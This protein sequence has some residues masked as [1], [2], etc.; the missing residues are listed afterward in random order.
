MQ[1]GNGT[2]FFDVQL[3]DNTASQVEAIRKN[4]ISKLGENIAP[5]VDATK[6]RSDIQ[7]A[8][9][10]ENFKIKLTTEK[11][12]ESIKVNIDSAHLRKSVQEALESK[13][14]KINVSVNQVR[15]AG[16]PLDSRTL[17][18]YNQLG[19]EYTKVQ[20]N[21]TQATNDFTGANM[22]M[23]ATLAKGISISGG[24]SSSLATLYSVTRVR[25]FLGNVIEIG[26][27]LERQRISIG[28]ILN[29]TAHATDLFDRIK[30]LAIKS[31]FGVVELDQYTKQLSAYGFKYN[32]LYDMTKRLA[33][34]SA[35]AGTD[36]G[37][38]TLALGHVRSA[39]YLTGI[40]LRQFSMNNIPMLKLLADQYSEVEKRAVSTAE[41]Q[42][43]ISER[44]VSY[45]DVITA[46]KTITDEGG[47]FYNMQDKISDSVSAKWKN[48]KDSLDIMYGEMA[49]SGIGDMLKSTAEGLTKLSRKWEELAHVLA[50]IVLRFGLVKASTLVNNLILGR[51]TNL[52]YKNEMAYQ[53]QYVA[54]L[55]AAQTYRK[56]SWDEQQVINSEIKLNE[57]RL[58]AIL[59]ARKLNREELS[60][61]VAL[62]KVNK[63]TAIAAIKHSD[64]TN[65]EKREMKATIKG[66]NVLKGFELQTAKAKL[67]LEKI[68]RTLKSLGASFG[69]IAILGVLIDLYAR[70]SEEADR[71]AEANDNFFNRAEEGLKNI[72]SMAEETGMKIKAYN[73]ELKEFTN[74]EQLG[75]A[76]KGELVAPEATN[77]DMQAAIE[78][79]TE[80]I[81]NY[82]ATPNKILN[83]ALVDQAGNVLSLSKQYENLSQSVNEV[84]QAYVYMKEMANNGAIETAINATGG[85]MIGKYLTDDIVTNINDYSDA[86][87]AYNSEINSLMV[88]YRTEISQALAAARAEG[89]F[90]TAI[91]AANKDMQAKSHRNLS[92]AEQLKML[93]ENQMKYSSAILDFNSKFSELVHKNG[94]SDLNVFGTTFLSGSSIGDEANAV[95]TA[96]QR[97][98]SD[99]EEF[100]NSLKESVKDMGYDLDHLKE[101][102]KQSIL[103]AI[104]EMVSK[105]TGSTEEVRKEVKKLAADK[106]KIIV[107]T[108]TADAIAKTSQLK[109]DLK[110]LVG[111][112]WHIDINT[113]TNFNDVIQK[114]RQEYKSAKDYI[115]NVKPLMLKM[116]FTLI[117]QKS[118]TKEQIDAAVAK[119][120]SK[121]RNGAA[122]RMALEDYKAAME[123]INDA[124]DFNKSTGIHLSDPNSGGKT[125]R[126]K[127]PKTSKTDTVLKGWQEQLTK[128]KDFYSS[129]KKLAEDLTDDQALARIRKEGLFGSLFD[130]S[131]KFIYDINNM[132]SAF[133]AL[134]KTVVGKVGKS[135]ERKSFLHN[136]DKEIVSVD[137]DELHKQI[138]NAAKEMDKYISEN[139]K[140]FDLFKK[141]F[142]A[143][144][145]RSMAENIAFGENVSYN[146]IVEK[147]RS[148]LGGKD[149]IKEL[150]G[151][152]KVLG[153]SEEE[154]TKVIRP[155][156]ELYHA[157]KQ[158]R[159]EQQKLSSESVNGLLDMYKAAKNYQDKINDVNLELAKNLKI[160]EEQERKGFIDPERANT[161]RTNAQTNATQKIDKISFEEFKN[162]SDWVKIFGD[163]NKVAT[164]KL[165]ELVAKLEELKL[166]LPASDAK[167]L[168]EAIDKINNELVDRN[169]ISSL[170]SDI[171]KRYTLNS[172]YNRAGELG[173]LVRNEKEAKATGKAI[174]DNLSKKE[175]KDIKS[176]NA[177]DINKDI[178]G[179]SKKFQALSNVL[180]PVTDLFDQLG[181]ETLSEGSN[182]VGN[183]LQSG[184]SVSNGLQAFGGALS[185]AG[186]WGA[187]AGAALSVTSSL[188]ALH[189]KS[190]QKQIEAS[191]RREKEMENLS[192]NL[193]SLLEDSI[194]GIFNS[195][196]SEDPE[197]QAKVNKRKD[198][199]QGEI[200]KSQR[201]WNIGL[202]D[203]RIL[204]YIKSLQESIDG[205]N[206]DSVYKVNREL[207][208][209]ELEELQKQRDAEADKKKSD[210]NALIEY[211]EK[212]YQKKRE[213]RQYAQTMAKDLYDIDFKSWANDLANTLVSAWASGESAAEKY[214]QKVSDIIKELG[215]KMISQRFVA[216][217]LEPIMNEFLDQYEL[218][219]GELTE[220]G[221]DI[222]SRMY[223]SA[224]E[225][226]DRSNA[227]MDGLEQIAKKNGSTL[228]S[229]DSSSNLIA[230]AKSITEDTAGLMASYL[231]SIR[232]DVS[233]IRQI[234]GDIENGFQGVSVIAKSQ[235]DR[236]DGILQATRS[237]AESNQA[238]YDLLRRA[239][240]SKDSGFYMQ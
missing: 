103:L 23:N 79:W 18:T 218:D 64:L 145:N 225:L 78:K 99:L 65:E 192:N 214:K 160:I 71:A 12:T 131:G 67:A 54:N 59:S 226:Q 4:L 176:E 198:Y 58:Q 137:H 6:I 121:G 183:A 179:V 50:I 164:D 73:G 72:Q 217:K 139:S 87:K 132:K 110:K 229:A 29:D 123:S 47:M 177:T 187:A 207:L 140:K 194:R 35:G 57:T 115:E 45:D 215:T 169:P 1:N 124:T 211:D 88:H 69:W 195:K 212:I 102:Q 181:N 9:N 107:D 43:R 94:K 51:N 167:A 141:I 77:S 178:D 41:V 172:M 17:S 90:S 161:L 75:G 130:K 173:T 106:F 96:K 205:L 89:K 235:L 185:K 91:K 220:K 223:E 196:V 202:R 186:P 33:D 111:H 238:M 156:S 175:L 38:L 36:V 204:E 208:K 149:K 136:L 44:K 120:V 138:D 151:I 144:G 7:K 15:T 146:N 206:S 155:T 5:R 85:G 108:D 62:G 86:I 109:Q 126:D 48:L 134:R 197:L 239:T 83:D 52:V 159:E 11:L 171:G 237:T 63:E 128:I 114:V 122:I 189:D 221:L 142:D 168:K 129:Y 182:I 158:L 16:S 14:F 180:K 21:A 153:M 236:L 219:N 116:G 101:E 201:M 100:A 227:F 22:S 20:Q 55:K 157:I 224:N 2:L 127:K 30:A 98:E 216:D 76:Y 93:A 191:Q 184:A 231:N 148:E 70:Q 200:N 26:G 170:F 213:I 82:S 56:L 32:E 105:A 118:L 166:N 84:A 60:R 13:D 135:T 152:D 125:F 143:T 117:G 163:L 66:T 113:S 24:L 150:G 119:A 222:I 154:L 209:Q 188:F 199:L 39:T 25:E 228:T 240:L 80:F 28:A 34:I 31:P 61:L 74:I 95:A 193:K 81:Q 49:E 190:L 46:L 147:L 19:R 92:E 162:T 8:L 104:G 97:M 53:K 232:A 210:K 234:E 42:Q 203:P 165:R 68:G 174:G 27:Q 112:E 230:G 3:K 37:R 133:E 40:T 10:S 233:V